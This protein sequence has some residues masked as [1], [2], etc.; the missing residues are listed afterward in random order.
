ML[1]YNSKS[2]WWNDMSDPEFTLEIES[3]SRLPNGW[4]HGEGIRPKRSIIKK[5]LNIS[6]FSYNHSFQ[7]DTAPGLNGEVQIAISDSN[8]KDKNYMEITFEPDGFIN[9]TSFEK[10]KDNWKIIE[11]IDVNSIVNVKQKILEFGRKIFICLN[12][13][14]YYQGNNTLSTLADTVVSPLKTYTAEYRLYP[15]LVSRKQKNQYVTI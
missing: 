1:T 15:N 10:T 8:S 12:S 6:R 14:E 9:L 13:S 7:V 2:F 5:A 3:Y 4:N 11:D